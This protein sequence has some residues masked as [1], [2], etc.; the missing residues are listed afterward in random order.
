MVEGPQ[1]KTTLSVAKA[2]SAER[3]GAEGRESAM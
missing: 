3:A 2:L 1:T